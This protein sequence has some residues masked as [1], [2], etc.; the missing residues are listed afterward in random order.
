MIISD[1]AARIITIVSV[2]ASALA[3][4]RFFGSSERASFPKMPFSS[5]IISG[6]S[7]Y[8]QKMPIIIGVIIPVSIESFSR[9]ASRLKISITASALRI[10][11]QSA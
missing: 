10:I 1:N 6:F 9:T 8:A 4:L 3:A 7:R 2:S 11:V 5:F